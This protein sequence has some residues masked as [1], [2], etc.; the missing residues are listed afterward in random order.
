MVVNRFEYVLRE[1]FLAQDLPPCLQA[2]G[3]RNDNVAVRYTDAAE[4]LVKRGVLMN[5]TK[6][7]Y[8]PGANF[9]EGLSKYGIVR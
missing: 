8:R 9:M 3:Q 4:Q 2:E 6:G 1:V 7:G 5:G